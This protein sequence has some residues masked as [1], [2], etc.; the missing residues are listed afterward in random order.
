MPKALLSPVSLTTKKQK[1]VPELT[2]SKGL[3]N[4]TIPSSASIAKTAASETDKEIPKL[5]LTIIPED[6]QLEILDLED[7]D[8]IDY[9]SDPRMPTFISD[10]YKQLNAQ[11]AL[12]AKLSNAYEVIDTLR[13]ELAEAKETIAKLHAVASSKSFDS[14]GQPTSAPLP[15]HEFPPIY[16]S[17]A[18]IHAPK[19]GSPTPVSGNNQRL[20]YKA[21]ASKNVKPRRPTSDNA[22]KAAAR[23]FTK[24]SA[25][26]GFKFLYVH[27]RGKTPRNIVRSRL[28]KMGVNPA[29]IIDIHYPDN[30]VMS[31]LIH[32]DYESELLSVFSNYDVTTIE[33]FNPVDPSILHDPDFKDWDE[34]ILASKAEE[35]FSKRLIS[36]VLRVTPVSLQVALSR[37]FFESKWLTEAQYSALL[38]H[39]NPPK[40]KPAARINSLVDSLFSGNLPASSND[41]AAGKDAA[42]EQ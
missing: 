1:I 6:D 37:S 13:A 14:S 2:R 12:I 33:D 40:E 38:T 20:S 41:Q 10:I 9:T 27:T 19:I 23:A 16:G 4:R 36:T 32:N 5:S 35:L 7:N 17:G 21:V 3:R 18:S 26:Q 8:D 39:I 22:K 34:K 28:R 25:T 24:V 31:L 30:Q 29:R 42:M 11:G 15:N